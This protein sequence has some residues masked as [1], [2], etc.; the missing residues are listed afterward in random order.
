MLIDVGAQA[1]TLDPVSEDMLIAL[2]AEVDNIVDVACSQTGG[3][4]QFDLMEF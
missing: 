4:D 2:A 1:D 3:M